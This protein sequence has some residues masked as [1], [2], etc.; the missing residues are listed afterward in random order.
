MSSEPSPTR[1]AV[2]LVDDSTEQRDLYQLMLGQNFETLS[3]S[4]G[5]QALMIAEDYQPSVVVLDICMP[6][7]DGFEVCRR[8]K[9]DPLTEGIPV[10][11]LTGIEDH[12]RPKAFLAGAFAVLTKPCSQ[13]KLTETISAAIGRS[14]RQAI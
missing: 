12:V 9:S 8:L 3:A 13:E 5:R 1:P 2:L 10:I 4:S 11:I 6:E 7:M 14:A